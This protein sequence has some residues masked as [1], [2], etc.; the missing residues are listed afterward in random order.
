MI[1]YSNNGSREHKSPDL[2]HQI[3]T[4][5]S[6]QENNTKNWEKNEEIQI[7]REYLRIPTVHPDVDYGRIF[8][9]REL[10]KCLTIEFSF[11]EYC[12][13]F[14]RKQSAFLGLPMSVY[15]PVN[16]KNPV[17]I[18]TWRGTQPELPSIVLNSHMDVVPV[19]EEFWT[20]PPFAA[21]MDENGNIF[22][23]GAQDMKSVG[24]QYL[25]AIRGLKRAG[26]GPFNRTIHIEFVPDEE[27]GEQGMP[28]FVRTEAF[29][30]MNVGFVLDE[31][32]VALDDKGTMPVYYAERTIWQVEFVFHS[33]H[34]G[35]GSLLFA[36]T[37]GEKLNYVLG[38][39]MEF[40]KEEAKKLNVLKYPYG[41]VTTINLTFVKGGVE[42]NVVPA[43]MRAVFDMRISAN[44]DLD[45]FEKQVRNYNNNFCS[46]HFVHTFSLK[47]QKINRWCE[48]A[49]GNITINYLEKRGKEK[50]TAVDD[51][52]PFWVAFDEA[53]KES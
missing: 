48:E 49:G 39:F 9:K 46:C 29:K 15:R 22:A 41:N 52:N 11:I 43:E 23:R 30:S 13:A 19:Y 31:G 51:S 12:V 25:A 50:A 24:M 21:E 27:V 34:S 2:I 36:N 18:M 44:A 45:E 53:T 14:L 47:F 17:A 4:S 3:P 20:H 6:I 5:H 42:N 35:H 32:G 8:F 33:D 1:F 38:K 28:G 37:A 10:H 40:R 7:F 16:D 26:I